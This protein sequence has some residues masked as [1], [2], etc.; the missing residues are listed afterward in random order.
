MR[1]MICIACPVGC[2]LTIDEN[3]HVEGNLCQRGEKYAIEEIT[4]PTRILTTTVKT[5][6]L[7][8]P[9]LSVK[10]KDPIPKELLFEAMEILNSI[11]IE[12]NVKIGDVIVKNI[13]NTGVDMVATRTIIINK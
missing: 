10:S 13:L 5:T 2:H 4:H 11:R 9:R 12:N 3:L 7:L 6:C 1:E 8:N